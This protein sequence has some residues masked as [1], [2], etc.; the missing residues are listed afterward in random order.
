M[1]YQI[2][3][4]FVLT[5]KCP[6]CTE[7]DYAAYEQTDA[8]CTSEGTKQVLNVRGYCVNNRLFGI[9]L[10]NIAMVALR[11]LEQKQLNAVRY[12]YIV[13]ANMIILA[14]TVSFSSTS[15]GLIIGFGSAIVLGALGGLIYFY[16]KHQKLYAS[17]QNLRNTNLPMDEP[18]FSVSED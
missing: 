9:K 1:G 15:I 14:K 2:R 5:F 11:H 12:H 18:Q 10:T 7:R 13:T 4:S 17:Y 6:L 16:K 8:E 3:N